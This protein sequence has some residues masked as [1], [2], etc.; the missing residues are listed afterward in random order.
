M[1]PAF[2]MA[3]FEAHT[4]LDVPCPASIV[5]GWNDDI[6]PVANS[7]RWAGERR[8]SLHVLDSDHRLQDRIPE[9]ARLF[10]SFLIDIDRGAPLSG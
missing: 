4:P 2:Y 8:A 6:V 10:R 7:I 9:I 1:A 5:H 3:G